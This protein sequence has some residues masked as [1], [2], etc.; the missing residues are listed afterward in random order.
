V[1]VLKAKGAPMGVAEIL[2][3]LLAN[4]LP[5]PARDPKKNLGARIYRLKIEGHQTRSARA[6]SPPNSHLPIEP[7]PGLALRFVPDGRHDDTTV[8]QDH[9][10]AMDRLPVL[11]G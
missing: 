2:E 11:R 7:A 6:S 4:R 3:G 1:Q 8:G 9:R 10:V 5:I